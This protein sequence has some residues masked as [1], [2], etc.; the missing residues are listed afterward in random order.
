MV[1]MCHVAQVGIREDGI[2]QLPLLPVLRTDG[3]QYA[4]AKEIA[5]GYCM[6]SKLSS[7]GLPDYQHS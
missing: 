2:E 1:K 6:Y 4:W 5:S 3:R 7:L